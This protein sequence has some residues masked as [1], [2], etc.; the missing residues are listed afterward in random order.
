MKRIS[1]ETKK[2]IIRES[3]EGTSVEKIAE[4]YG[5]R[6]ETVYKYLKEDKETW[7]E[8]EL[9]EALHRKYGRG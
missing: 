9:W 5:I 2:K 6:K 7:P 3:E 8:W 1:E 4:K